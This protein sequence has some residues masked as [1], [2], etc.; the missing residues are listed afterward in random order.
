MIARPVF[1][2]TLT[3]TESS[4]ALTAEDVKRMLDRHIEVGSE[5]PVSY[6]PIKTIHEVLGL[7]ISEYKALIEKGAAKSLA[8]YPEACCITSGAVY[9]YDHE[10]LK[11]IPDAQKKLLLDN[12]WTADPV[13]FITRIAAEWL[14]DENPVLPIVRRASGDPL[15]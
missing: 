9:A 15:M 7:K 3:M 12:G 10:G 11:R 2:R 5:R 14:D 4:S 1:A 13:Q 8:L 6:L